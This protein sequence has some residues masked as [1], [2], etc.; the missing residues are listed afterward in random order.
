MAQLKAVAG[1]APQVEAELA[2]LNRDYDVLHKNY[3]QLARGANRRRWREDVDSQVSMAE[4]RVID[5]PRISPK[6]VFPNR[7]ALMPVV[8]SLALA[9]GLAMQLGGVADP[10]DVPRCEAAARCH[11]ARRARN[12]FRCRRRSRSFVSGGSG[13]LGLCRR[14]GE[15]AGPLWDLDHLGCPRGAMPEG[16]RT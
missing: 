10:A 15:P 6:A 13:Q 5:P 4:F 11:R 1:R 12:A 8:L 7:L 9:A 3:D 16:A 14:C 2:Q